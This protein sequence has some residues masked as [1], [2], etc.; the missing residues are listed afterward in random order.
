MRVGIDIGSITATRTGVGNYC[1]CLLRH[2]IALGADCEF[3]GFSSGTARVVAEALGLR[4]PHRH[5][6]IPTRALYLMWDHLG[7]PPIERLL[8]SVD[9]YHATNYYLP[10][11][12]RA[13]RV[14]TIHD[15]SFLVQPA[16]SSPR[17]VGPFSRGMP[18]F[19]READAIIAYSEATRSD[20]VTRLGV[21][22]SKV[23]VAPLATDETLEPLP[24]DAAA[25]LLRER[26][27]I[28]RPYVLFVGTLE[29]RKNV[30]TLLRAFA[31]LASEFPHRL[32]LAGAVG[33]RPEETL[34]LLERL[35]LGDRVVRTGY[36]P[37]TRVLAALY[38]A[39]DLF[40]FPSWYEGFGLPVLEA[41]TC[42]CP[43]IASDT[44]A[45]PEV[46]GDAALLVPPSDSQALADAM[47]RVL[48]EPALR[49]SLAERGRRRAQA[50]SWRA[51]AERTLD[52]YR[53]LA[54]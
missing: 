46:A 14:V 44:S 43:V 21:P 13:R 1:L 40:A 32:V 16:W 53:S 39:A 49:S 27:G 9:V 36:V 45:M 37:D 41:M 54:P 7:W 6:P 28:E 17:I 8:G 4:L 2:L 35:D 26:Y 47:R 42:G 11:A 31:A 51:C 23:T 19:A 48:G 18:R 25:A 50:F 3:R 24:V 30:S 33:W 10:P 52:V 22:A 5:F 29:P 15:L 12:R 38:S 34:A 20:I